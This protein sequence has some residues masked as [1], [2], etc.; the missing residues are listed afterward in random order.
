MLSPKRIRPFISICTVHD[1][2]SSPSVLQGLPVLSPEERRK[3]K[4]GDEKDL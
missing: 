1:F 3:K 2:L 4:A